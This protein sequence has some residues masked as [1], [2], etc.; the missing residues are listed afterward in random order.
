IK[1][2]AKS[3]SISAASIIAKV[4]RDR[5][6][7]EL[8]EKYPAYGF[9]QHMGYGTKQHLEAIEAHGVLEEHRKSFAP[10]KDMI[11]K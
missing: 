7:K 5:M 9:E 10:I 4:T 6:M 2:D 3:I 8:G 1:G 11:Q